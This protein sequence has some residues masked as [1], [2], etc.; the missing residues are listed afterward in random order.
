MEDVKLRSKNWVE[1]LPKDEDDVGAIENEFFSIKGRGK[2]RQFLPNKVLDLY[3]GISYTL[4]CDIENYI[5]EFKTGSESISVCYH[6]FY[7]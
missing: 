4:R 7:Y 1:M 2:L 3:L 6:I 5:E